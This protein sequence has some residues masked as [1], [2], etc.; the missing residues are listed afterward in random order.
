MTEATFSYRANNASFKIK[1][2]LVSFVFLLFTLFAVAGTAL[3]T[4]TNQGTIAVANAQD[5]D[6]K[7]FIM[8][9]VFPAPASDIY[10]F[11]TTDD[12]PFEF[13]SKSIASTGAQEIDS[14]YNSLLTIGTEDD[15][16]QTNVAIL[17]REIEA[18]P[19]ES[20][21]LDLTDEQR[22]ALEEAKKAAEQ[23]RKELV[24]SGQETTSALNGG[25][26]VNP[27][28]R[29]GMAGLT[30]SNYM[31]EW[32]Y[33]VVDACARGGEPSDPK[34]GLM[35]EDRLVPQ[36]TWENR[37]NSNDIRVIQ[38]TR[39]I[40]S[41]FMSS[42]MNVAANLVFSVTKFIVALTLS[43]IFFSFSDVAE[44]IGIEDLLS[45]GDGGVFSALFDGIFAPLLW[46]AMLATG[47]RIFWL[48]VVQRQYRKSIGE[49]G[50]AL[51][52]ALLGFIAA[53]IPQTVVSFPNDVATVGQALVVSAV[54]GSITNT[55]GICQERAGVTEIVETSGITDDTAIL[56][57]ANQAIRASVGC[58]YWE[59]FL[60]RPWSEAQFGENYTKLWAQDGVQRIGA[61]ISG[62]EEIQ[63]DNEKMVGE[64][65]VPLGGGEYINNWAV[66]QISAQTNVHAQINAAY[67]APTHYT[68]GI[69]SDLWRLVDALANYDEETQVDVVY[70]SEEGGTSKI[71]YDRQKTSNIPS[72]YWSQWVGN[73]NIGRIGT[74]T[75]SVLV[76]LV[77]VAVPL[78]FAMTSAML[79]VGIA[80]IMAFAPFALLAGVWSG[81]GRRFFMS[82]LSLLLNAVIKRIVAGLLLVVTLIGQTSLLAMSGELSFWS[83]LFAVA[84]FSV[85][86]WKTRDKIFAVFASF[87]LGGN[88]LQ[89]SANTVVQKSKSAGRKG[90]S[91]ATN[92]AA[93]GVGGAMG[94]KAAGGT[95][96][97]GVYDGMK[98]EFRNMALR[99][100][101]LREANTQYELTKTRTGENS[102]K[103]KNCTACGT[104]LH[105]D[106]K[107]KFKGGIIEAGNYLCEKCYNENIFPEATEVY[108][109]EKDKMPT[110][111]GWYD[112]QLDAKNSD[113]RQ[114]QTRHREAFTGKSKAP[115]KET[116]RAFDNM[117]KGKKVF[118]GKGEPQKMQF[119]D[120][121]KQKMAYEIADSVKF[122]MFNFKKQRDDLRLAGD[123]RRGGDKNPI[124]EIP[125]QLKKYIDPSIMKQAWNNEDFEYLSHM[126]AAGIS[127]YIK[128][129]TEEEIS[130]DPD[131]LANEIHSAIAD[132]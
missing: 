50:M 3:V 99:N 43:L 7:K 82:W 113:L 44:A 17:G 54:G 104:E 36:D 112:R 55:E 67:G 92:F 6:W 1:K 32:K 52:M 34:S 119:S 108:F 98:Y 114:V 23:I 131:K 109:K 48:G 73:N 5:G 2:F 15:F 107:G 110:R 70:K 59:A 120:E 49:F 47:A 102:I 4:L 18:K 100:E 127:G 33:L 118:N 101:H 30:F 35:Y 111:Q 123:G 83:T 126:Y 89:Q 13:R 16:T 95:V 84:L 42:F 63:Y 60:L 62:A 115:G 94:A 69:A 46:I 75:G 96:F 66:F 26:P 27:Y 12:L 41:H 57:E 40:F 128:D 124:P 8:C 80:I 31:G 61:D 65:S 38:S 24:Q 93:S 77:G 53:A 25:E 10:Q 29:F 22:E 71:Q 11:M 37:A 81:A 116:Q 122:D 20:L 79:S 85:I 90:I 68:S 86:M 88:Q 106:S 21:Q 51:L 97:G 39:G 129:N 58:Q 105:Y 19:D 76:A 64:A 56:E 45:G 132:K 103:G 74:A 14:F 125:E 117:E 130:I 121:E 72:E 9:S 28:E 87:N 91:T 78:L